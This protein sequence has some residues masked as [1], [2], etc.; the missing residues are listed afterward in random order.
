M[1][2]VMT[3]NPS[4]PSGLR[5]RTCCPSIVTVSAIVTSLVGTTLCQSL[6]A[7]GG[8]T[9]EEVGTL[10][11]RADALLPSHA[12]DVHAGDPRE[13]AQPAD[14]LDALRDADRGG[15]RPRVLERPDQLAG[16]R[17]TRDLLVQERGLPG[18]A[19]RGHPDDERGAPDDAAGPGALDPSRERLN[20][21][22]DLRHH[23][24]GAGVEL[25]LEARGVVAR[26]E[27][28]VRDADEEARRVLD[29]RAREQ[30]PVLAQVR[31]EPDE[32]LDGDVVDRGGVGVIA[33]LDR[34]AGQAEQVPSAERPPAKEVGREPEPVPIPAGELH[35]GL[36]P[37]RGDERHT[38][39]GRHVGGRSGVVRH[40]HGIRVPAELARLRAHGGAIS[41]ARWDDLGGDAED[42]GADEALQTALGRHRPAACLSAAVTVFTRSIATVIGP[43]PPGTGVIAPA[44]S[45]TPSKCT[46]PMRPPPGALLV[47]TSMTVAPGLTMSAVIISALPAAATMMSARL[48]WLAM[49]RV[50]VWQIVTVAFARSC[51]CASM[52][53]R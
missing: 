23:E 20:V 6:R 46:S 10:D 45:L 11:D 26:R 31:R 50:F 8:R 3:P 2:I 36:E 18:A 22:D 12:H 17:D 25:G 44:T 51:R 28:H 9:R 19:E 24:T 5:F 42:P 33:D 14:D 15:V 29:H 40:V 1:P 16:H 13:R 47:P 41:G 39:H 48:V 38:R 4:T 35:R 43:T 34:V 30:P 37:G 7:E 49:S 27:G 52:I 53:A 21:V 32:P